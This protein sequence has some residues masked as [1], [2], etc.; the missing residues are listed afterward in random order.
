M[1]KTKL[2]GLVT[3]GLIL[4][5]L[6][7]VIRWAIFQP[8]LFIGTLLSIFGETGSNGL[9]SLINNIQQTNNG[10]LTNNK[11]QDIRK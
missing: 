5:M 4:A 3:G 9:L 2:Y 11:Q 6:L 1:Q 10:L 7:L 8:I